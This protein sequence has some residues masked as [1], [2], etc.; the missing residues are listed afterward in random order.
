V[1]K[2]DE[3]FK[4]KTH[5]NILTCQVGSF[6]NLF[7]KIITAKYLAICNILRV[8]TINLIN[9]RYAKNSLVS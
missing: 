2:K 4:D 9:L 8:I 3:R 5:S 6:S 1:R 7:L